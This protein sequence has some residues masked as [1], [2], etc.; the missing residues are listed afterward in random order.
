[1]STNNYAITIA[2]EEFLDHVS[3]QT[4][5]DSILEELAPKF[6]KWEPP[7][8][9]YNTKNDF[10]PFNVDSQLFDV[11]QEIKGI[12]YVEDEKLN[13]TPEKIK[14]CMLKIQAK[15]KKE[16]D[17]ALDSLDNS[18]SFAFEVSD[19][20]GQ[21]KVY[22]SKPEE[23]LTWS[24]S[25]IDEFV[26]YVEENTDADVLAEIESAETEEVLGKLDLNELWKSFQPENRFYLYRWQKDPQNLLQEIIEIL[27]TYTNKISA[28]DLAVDVYEMI[29][30]G[31]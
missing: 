5:S 12:E 29:S 28:E 9:I 11:Q 27:D 3:I 23:F 17:E 22:I 14:E 6:D 18:S 19:D 10:Y 7:Y 8:Y 24:D 30:R 1:M 31:E 20:L 13:A 15:A 21:V 26:E 4:V 16:M 2:V 25:L